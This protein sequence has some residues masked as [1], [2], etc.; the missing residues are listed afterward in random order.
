MEKC[1]HDPCRCK[2]AESGDYCSDHC[3]SV[4]AEGPQA[5]PE[6]CRCGHEDCMTE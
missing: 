6:L 3:R 1:A 5:G 4:A 2:V